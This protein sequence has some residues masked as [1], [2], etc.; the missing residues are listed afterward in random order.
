MWTAAQRQ[1]PAE[2]RSA[3]RIAA[4]SEPGTPMVV[5]GRV[6]K[7]DGVT[8]AAG[9]ILFAYQTD[10]SGL[11]N[12]P[13]SPGW[14]LQGWAITDGSGRF[15]LATIRPGSYP[16]RTVP[17]HIHFTAES[18][19]Y[20]RQWTQELRFEDDPLVPAAERERS[21]TEG[22]F[23]GVRPPRIENGIQHVEFTIRLK[24]TADF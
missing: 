2:L 23:G 14:R 1:R 11:Y 8:P 17:A 16:S 13:G 7:P 15:E 6:Y 5:H 3:S 4:S 20:P 21:R 22:Q 18:P 24:N 10:A 19:D 9:V 12:R